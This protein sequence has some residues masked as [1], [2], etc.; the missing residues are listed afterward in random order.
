MFIGED[1]IHINAEKGSISNLVLMPGD[2]L[3]AKYIAEHFLENAKEVCNL[4][5]MLGYTGIYKGVRVSVIGSGMGMPSMGIYSFELYHFFNVDKIIR[6][7]TCG[8]VSEEVE[9]PELILAEKAYSE[10]NFAYTFDNYDKHITY[11]SS[12][13][14]E[15]IKETSKELNIKIHVGDVTT[16]DVFGPYIDY[17]RVLD[18]MPKDLH[19]LG[20]EMEAFGL[21]H[22]AA[23][24]KKEASCILTAVDSKFSD[25]VLSG[26]QRET[27]LND[28]IKL[29]L[30]SIIK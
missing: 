3:R 12:N 17:D 26:E 6:I 13:L 11:P 8:V 28:M 15:K 20:E 23:H 25:V 18:R 1:P 10:T 9:V 29:A 19:V 24:F 30:E 4:R 5:N 2:P 16:M 21:F 22:I 7:G 14:N 27:S